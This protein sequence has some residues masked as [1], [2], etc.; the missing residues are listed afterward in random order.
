MTHGRYEHSFR[1]MNTRIEFKFQAAASGVEP[2]LLLTQN[3]FET[4]EQRFS[5]FRMDSEL[6]YLN[7]ANGETCLVSDH[8][9]E[10]LQ[11]AEVYRI[12]TEHVFEPFVL[13]ALEGAGYSASFEQLGVNSLQSKQLYHDHKALAP[14][15]AI[16]AR[17]KS[18]RLPAG[19]QLDLGGIVKSWA[20]KRLAS[21]FRKKR[22]VEQ[23]L[24]NAGGDLL[25]W[26]SDPANGHP[27]SIEIEDPWNPEKELGV[28]SC[29]EKAAA[30][31]SK[32][33]RRWHNQQGAQHHLIDPRTMRSS[34][35]DTVQCTVI[36]EDPVECEIWSKTI[37]ILGR[38]EGARLLLARAPGYEALVFTE[39]RQ[40]HMYGSSAS[41]ESS[42]K[43]VDTGNFHFH[44]LMKNG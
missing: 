4:V 42:W 26:S 20:V 13:Q 12:K 7:R 22:G 32:L 33:G 34:T 41:I 36:G 10:V 18:V 40:C 23:G 44:G 27:W 43:S 16:D 30:T 2:L 9:L 5:R 6:C 19:L 29:S 17:M 8:M 24:L 39:D 28:M 38:E 21:Y 25:A 15:I 35:S 14:S 3:W 37:C 31:S 1:A 11:L